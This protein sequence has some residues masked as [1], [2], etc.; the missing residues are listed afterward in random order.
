MESRLW[1]PPVSY[2]ENVWDWEKLSLFR[3]MQISTNVDGR[4]DQRYYI[5]KH[6]KSER[7]SVPVVL[8]CVQKWIQNLR[9]DSRCYLFITN[10]LNL[11]SQ[12]MLVVDPLKRV[13]CTRL[14]VV[15][16]ELVQRASSDPKHL[17]SRD[18]PL[19]IT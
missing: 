2:L 11:I 12:D 1:I 9:A 16:S 10:F 13:D 6:P 18:E 14:N 5:I 15:L 7:D 8:T 17:A 4:E 3:R 19:A